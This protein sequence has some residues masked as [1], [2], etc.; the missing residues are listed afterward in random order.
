MEGLG[1]FCVICVV[2]YYFVSLLLPRVL[3]W[4]FKQRFHVEVHIGKISFLYFRLQDVHIKKNE[5]SVHIEEVGFRSNFF[6]SEVTKLLAVVLRDVRINKDVG[7]YGD[8]SRTRHRLPDDWSHI[9]FRNKK[10]P[11]SI[12]TFAQFMAVHITNFNAM[13]LHQQSPEWLVHATA[14]EVNL[15]GSVVHSAR[16]LLVNVMLVNAAAKLLRHPPA[17]DKST[18]QTCLGELSFGVTLE[19][20][21]AAQGSLSVEKLHVSLEHLKAVINDGLYTFAAQRWKKEVHHNRDSGKKDCKGNRERKSP[22]SDVAEHTRPQLYSPSMV[23]SSLS[24]LIPKDMTLKMENSHL[25]GMRAASSTEFHA[26]LNSLQIQTSFLLKL[27]GIHGESIVPEV[28]VGLQLDEFDVRDEREKVFLLQKLTL[29]AGL[30]NKF[31]KV[32]L[33]LNKLSGTYNHR[34]V[35][36]WVSTNFLRTSHSLHS[37]YS[38]HISHDPYSHC[39]SY[40]EDMEVEPRELSKKNAGQSWVHEILSGCKVSGSLELFD[41]STRLRMSSSE[42]SACIG[43]NHIRLGLDQVFN[44]K[45]V[46]ATQPLE[47]WSGELLIEALW[48]R[49]GLSKNDFDVDIYQRRRCHVWG[50]PLFLGV[51]LL[52]ARGRAGVIFPH[53]LDG[54]LNMLCGEWSP[55][56]AVFIAHALKCYGDYK[57]QR[58][59]VKR[60]QKSDPQLLSF[61]NS[62][63]ISANITNANLFFITDPQV[64]VMTRLDS[65]IVEKGF[66]SV[67]SLEG[68]KAVSLIPSGNPY[69]C[70]KSEEVKASCAHIQQARIQYDNQEIS[71]QLLEE[72]FAVWSANFHLRILAVGEDLAQFFSQIIDKP[73]MTSEEGRLKSSF[74][75][76]LS[77]VNVV[78]PGAAPVK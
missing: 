52:N 35:H 33:C 53:K 5:L 40:S 16:S 27:A 65:I 7:N 36:S 25:T 51:M 54:M 8:G 18:P 12:I 14:A 31:L 66:K 30:E 34:A 29:K 69:N 37:S 2:L 70:L 1:V 62:C 58:E 3:A 21:M 63:A 49:L 75:N 39:S 24:P 11:P 22:R 41:V 56:L 57:R 76:V 71:V 77:Q 68:C 72:I 4:L 32:N 61:L 23:L 19:A 46:T 28:S 78:A 47:D 38:S 9:D 20:M 45:C 55:Q 15:D 50:T 26:S 73:R 60:H 6:S 74:W 43:C 48:C 17:S 13:L 59:I 67:M 64:G 44:L 42:G 10:I